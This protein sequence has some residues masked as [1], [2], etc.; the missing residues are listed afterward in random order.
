MYYIVHRDKINKGDKMNKTK[1]QYQD[2]YKKLINTT[3]KDGNITNKKVAYDIANDMGL[4]VVKQ[5][6][7]SYCLE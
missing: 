5:K 7:G 4:S 2:E 3:N 6:D 1:K